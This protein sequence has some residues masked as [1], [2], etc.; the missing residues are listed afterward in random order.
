MGSLLGL[1]VAFGEERGW[2][3]FLQGQLVRLGKKRGVLIVG[4]IWGAWHYPIIWMGYNYP[5]Y[6]IAGT[7]MMTL[8]TV[9]LAFVFGYALLKTGSIW[10]VAF[11]HA[12]F[13]QTVAYIGAFVN[14]PDSPIFSFGIGLYCLA[15]LAVIVL[16]LLRDPIWRNGSATGDT[17]NPA[18]APPGT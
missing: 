5:G 9:L 13:D 11:M 10:I 2:R 18:V 7:A 6:P 4:M 1:V 12:V 3:G 17:G 16:L 14:K 15:I 8:L